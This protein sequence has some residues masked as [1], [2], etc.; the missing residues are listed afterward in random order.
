M[1]GHPCET[2]LRWPECNGTAWGSCPHSVVHW[3]LPGPCPI[4]PEQFEA[5]YNDEEE[6]CQCL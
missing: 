6:T 2:C 5:I 4:T 1:T 3:S